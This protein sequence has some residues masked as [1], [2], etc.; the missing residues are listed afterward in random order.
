MS[1]AFFHRHFQFLTELVVI[2]SLIALAVILRLNSLTASLTDWHSFRQ[3]DTASVTLEYVKHGVDVLHP[4]YHDYSNI[5]SGLPNPNGHRM[6]EF[7]WI[8]GLVATLVRWQPTWDLVV[9]S[10]L[11]SIAFSVIT[12]VSLYYLGRTWFNP[13]VATLTG[14]SFATLPYAVFYSRVVLPEPAVIATSTAALASFWWWAQKG[15]WGKWLLSTLLFTLAILLKPFVV[16]V[17]PVYIWLSWWRWRQNIWRQLGLW[18]YPVLGLLALW[19]WRTWIHNFPEGIPA[20]DWLYNSNG[21]RWRPAWFRWL[22]YERLTKLILGWWGAPF[23]AIGFWPPTWSV[24]YGAVLAWWLGMSAYLSVIAT[25]NVRHDYYQVL[26]LPIVSLSLGL[27]LVQFLAV[28]DNLCQ[29]LKTRF[30][31]N[32]T[33]T[34]I[35]TLS[36]LGVGVAIGLIWLGGRQIV[37]TYYGTR[38][39]W[40]EAGRVANQLLPADAKV[41]AP[42]FGDTA[43]MFQINRPG[44]PIGFEIEDKIKRGATH[45]VTTTYDDEAHQLETQYQVIAKEPLDNPRYLIIDLRTEIKPRPEVETHP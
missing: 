13:T 16:F 15:G 27:G 43:F 41:I 8:N 29:L 6:V 7:P 30:K 19:Q 42:A 14:L 37:A 10:R 39:D 44:W 9:T 4:T 1:S 5:A 23:L 18:L 22:G 17:A 3:A 32:L 11:T 33:P 40:E 21:I 12:L 28:A 31:L 45:Y 25:G 35:T 24:G 36:W 2:A 38:S 34:G 26:L 20:S